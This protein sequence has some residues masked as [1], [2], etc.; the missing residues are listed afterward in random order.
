MNVNRSGIIAVDI[1]EGDALLDVVQT[2]GNDDLLLVTARGM[3]IR[4]HESDARDMGRNAAGVKG[5]ELEDGDEV[6]GGAVVPMTTDSDGD[7]VTT[8]PTLSLLTITEN[9]YGKRTSVDE[10]RVQPEQGKMRSQ[11]RGGKGR[12]DIKTVDRNGRSVAAL[13]VHEAD[14]LVVATMQGQLVRMPVGSISLYGRGTQGVRITKLNDGDKVAAA[15]RAPRGA[16]DDGEPADQGT[17][18]PAAE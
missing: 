2:T 5:I 8:D 6:V 13:L 3:A 16:A 1:R 4:F 12:V 14:D 15:S 7:T 9:G 17:P 10:Y 18:G 11:S